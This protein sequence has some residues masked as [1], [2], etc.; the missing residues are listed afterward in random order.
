MAA[1]QDAQVRSRGLSRDVGANASIAVTPSNQGQ[2]PPYQSTVATA[3]SAPAGLG[4]RSAHRREDD[5][6][7]CAF[8]RDTPE[9]REH[10]LGVHALRL[11]GDEQEVGAFQGLD[12][13][14][15]E[16][17]EAGIAGYQECALDQGR[18][19]AVDDQHAVRREAPCE[20]GGFIGEALRADHCG[21]PSRQGRSG[22][23][24]TSRRRRPGLESASVVPHAAAS[25]LIGEL[26]V[27]QRGTRQ[28]ERGN[29]LRPP[30]R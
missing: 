24:V 28:L 5:R 1:A 21:M 16:A 27:A 29:V 6:R 17:A 23:S 18:R 19:V 8:G 2:S 3:G 15:S 12:D 30:A 9:H 11:I 10:P 7:R 20:L 14:T 25:Q 4:G 22:R 26:V 13:V